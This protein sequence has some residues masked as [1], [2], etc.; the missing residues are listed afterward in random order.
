MVLLAYY[1][2]FGL[3]SYGMVQYF[4]EGGLDSTA[5]PGH[6]VASVT[7]D[8]S[9]HPSGGKWTAHL[10]LAVLIPSSPALRQQSS[11][12]LIIGTR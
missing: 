5:Q 9:G 1:F 12:A 10:D 11:R 6:S 2:A 4:G 3:A 7:N 8:I